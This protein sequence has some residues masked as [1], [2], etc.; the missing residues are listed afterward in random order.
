MS[1]KS[2]RAA[3]MQL[4]FENVSG[5]DGGEDTLRMIY[6]QLHPTNPDEP[7]GENTEVHEDGEH[8]E[9]SEAESAGVCLDISDEDREYTERLLNGVLEHLD[10][11]DHRI[12]ACSRGW[13]LNR[14]PLVDLTILRLAAWEILFE[15]DADVPDA[16]AINEAIELAIR[17]SDPEK[18]GRFINGVLG[19]IARNRDAAP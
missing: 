8:A 9:L 17:Y 12:E 2:A 7:I 10:E 1:R 16:V 4:I 14:M 13:A 15:D 11:L 3:A 6:E 19:T 5:G 18:S